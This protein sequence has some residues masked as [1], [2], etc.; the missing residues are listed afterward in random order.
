MKKRI[1]SRNTISTD[2]LIRYLKLNDSTFDEV[3]RTTLEIQGTNV[4]YDV[5]KFNRCAYIGAYSSIKLNLPKSSY[6]EAT[7]LLWLKKDSWPVNAYHTIYSSRYNGI[8]VL[9]GLAQTNT[10]YLIPGTQTEASIIAPNTGSWQFITLRFRNGVYDWFLNAVKKNST[11]GP[12]FYTHNACL[13][14]DWIN[15]SYDRSLYG[16]IDEF[17]FFE[18]ALSDEEIAKLYNNGKGLELW[19][20]FKNK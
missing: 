20:T 12:F 5:G 8:T 3:S 9:G 17:I 6:P 10:F 19:Y 16:Y 4:N 11:A 2:G 7:M 1:M 13:G 14:R 15:N 18:R